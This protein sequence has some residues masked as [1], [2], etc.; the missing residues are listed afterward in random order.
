MADVVREATM[1]KY[2]KP[3]KLNKTKLIIEEIF[4]DSQILEYS[5]SLALHCKD[6]RIPDRLHMVTT[7]ATF[8]MKWLV[9]C[10]LPRQQETE[11]SQET[12]SV[13]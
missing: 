2:H 3:C 12:L 6:I 11:C 1:T 9:I 4:P 8:V 10:L 5:D 7:P 13:G